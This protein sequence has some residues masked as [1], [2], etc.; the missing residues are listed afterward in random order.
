MS[1]VRIS[2]NPDYEVFIAELRNFAMSFLLPEHFSGFVDFVF[3]GKKQV[4]YFYFQEKEKEEIR[5]KEMP[6]SSLFNPP[7]SNN[8]VKASGLDILFQEIARITNF[9]F[10]KLE[11]PIEKRGFDN[12]LAYLL[13]DE[14]LSKMPRGKLSDGAMDMFCD[15]CNTEYGKTMSLFFHNDTLIAQP[16]IIS[17]EAFYLGFANNN[18][19]N[20]FIKDDK[21]ERENMKNSLLSLYLLYNEKSNF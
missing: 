17:L 21:D 1:K 13:P 4:C 8:M 18:D 16:K 11:N 15:I 19:C 20:I 5:T 10:L 3:S 9:R 14:F 12:D 7:E 6:L 2:H